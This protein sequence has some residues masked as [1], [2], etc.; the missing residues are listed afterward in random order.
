MVCFI[1]SSLLR[2]GTEKNIF[3]K[4]IAIKNTD[5]V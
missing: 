1:K 3:C 2:K 4:K 5:Q